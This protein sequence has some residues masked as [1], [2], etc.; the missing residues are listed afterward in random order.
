M[1]IFKDFYNSDK[2]TNRYVSKDGSEA[3]FDYRVGGVN[4]RMSVTAT[5]SGEK[6]LIGAWFDGLNYDS[7]GR[8]VCR[9]QTESKDFAKALNKIMKLCE[10]KGIEFN[11]GYGWYENTSGSRWKIIHFN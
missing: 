9:F 4:Y 2:A 1:K 7:L 3:W 11:G 6:Y 10:T 8:H 5:S